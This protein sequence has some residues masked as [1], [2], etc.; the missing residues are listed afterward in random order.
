[1]G[2]LNPVI[3]GAA[4]FAQR[5]LKNPLGQFFSYNYA[6]TGSWSDPKV[7]KIGAEPAQLRDPIPEAPKP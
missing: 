1:V 4:W 7:V 3:G 6:V 2:I 5:V